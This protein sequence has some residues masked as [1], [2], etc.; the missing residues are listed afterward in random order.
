MCVHAAK[1]TQTVSNNAWIRTC[2]CICVSPR[3]TWLKGDRACP[4]DAWPD[5]ETKRQPKMCSLWGQHTLD[6]AIVSSICSSTL[7]SR[8][9]LH[10]FRRCCMRDSAPRATAACRSSYRSVTSRVRNTHPG[11]MQPQTS[12]LQACMTLSY[13]LDAHYRSIVTVCCTSSHD[14]ITFV[15]SQVLCGLV[16]TLADAHHSASVAC[17]LGLLSTRPEMR[18]M[19]NH[20]QKGHDNSMP[21]N[22]HCYIFVYGV[23]LSS[24]QILTSRRYRSLDSVNRHTVHVLVLCLRVTLL[25]TEQVGRTYM[26][27]DGTNLKPGHRTLITRMSHVLWS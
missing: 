3:N 25:S 24:N 1:K 14:A 15:A 22:F 26:R 4:A 10:H 11:R 5:G 13:L 9:Q 19:N 7:C 6:I 21:C 8:Q 16:G 27:V 23:L 18:C 17:Q 12:G 2:V 20:M